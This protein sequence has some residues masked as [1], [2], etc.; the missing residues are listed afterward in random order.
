[1]L[2][3]QEANDP[4]YREVLQKVTARMDDEQIHEAKK[5]AHNIQEEYGI[6]LKVRVNQ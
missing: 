5:L 1:L 2:L 6:N 4:L 3:S